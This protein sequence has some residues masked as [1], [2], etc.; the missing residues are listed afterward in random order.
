[1]GSLVFTQQDFIWAVGWPRGR[2]GS[3]GSGGG[4]GG[5]GAV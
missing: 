4:G 2:G 5:G 3:G 1:M